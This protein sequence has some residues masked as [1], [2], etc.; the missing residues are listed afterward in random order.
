M[1]ASPGPFD[2]TSLV[3]VMP[4]LVGTAQMAVLNRVWRRCLLNRSSRHRRGLLRC[5]WNGNCPPYRRAGCIRS[6][7]LFASGAM[8]R[9]DRDGRRFTWDC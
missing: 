4:R 9:R 8:A 6:M 2:E 1:I 5:G 3:H 7:T